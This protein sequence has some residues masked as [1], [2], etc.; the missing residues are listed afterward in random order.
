MTQVLADSATALM[1]AVMEKAHQW[2][3]VRRQLGQA[4]AGHVFSGMQRRLMT[5]QHS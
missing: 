5:L 1:P 3:Q 2:A 4:H